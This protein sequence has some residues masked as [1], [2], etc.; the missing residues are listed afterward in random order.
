M[1]KTVGIVGLG[2]MG[3]GMALNL[4]RSGFVVRGSDVRDEPR[5]KLVAAGGIAAATPS[6]AGEGAAA[7]LVMVVNEAQARAV[8][9]GENGLIESLRPGSTV[10]L[11][12]TIGR[13]HAR[14]I[15]AILADQGIHMID[16]GVS[17]GLPSA[18]D[19]TLTLMASGPKAVFDANLDVLHAVGDP[20]A[21]FHVGEEIGAGQVVKACMQALVG[22]TFQGTFEALVLGAKAGVRPEV[23]LDVLGSSVVGSPLFKRATSFIMER[24]F[25]DTGSHI[26]VTFKD[27]GLTLDLAREVGVPMYSTALAAQLFQ[28]GMTS[29]PGEDNWAIVKVLETMADTV[30]KAENS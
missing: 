12:A 6:E 15:A 20:E 8:V 4:L 25:V 3:F 16:S 21:V 13:D 1:A 26:S 22:V 28:A 14:D 17:G 9:Y 18:N 5:E 27:L 2:N 29:Y 10:I 11:T 19:G 30:V 24:N 7:V 23:L